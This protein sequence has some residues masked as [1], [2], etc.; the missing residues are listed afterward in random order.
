MIS[1]AMFIAALRKGNPDID[2]KRALSI[3]NEV[4]SKTDLSALSPQQ[5]AQLAYKLAE[6]SCK[7]EKKYADG[8]MI[9]TPYGTIP[10]QV[11]GA[12]TEMPKITDADPQV[13][14]NAK[15]ALLGNQ[16]NVIA[17]NKFQDPNL[18]NQNLRGAYDDYAKRMAATGVSASRAV[19][20]TPE[21]EGISTRNEAYNKAMTVGKEEAVNKALLDQYKEGVVAN[22]ALTTNLGVANENALKHTK[23]ASD[24]AV[25]MQENKYKMAYGDPNSLSS[26]AAR[27]STKAA[28]KA[29]GQY[30]D[31]QIA[32]MVPDNATAMY[33][34]PVLSTLVPNAQ[35]ILKEATEIKK[36]DAERTKFLAD[37]GH[38]SAQAAMVKEQTKGEQLRNQMRTA[39]NATMIGADGKLNMSGGAVPTI[40]GGGDVSV[41]Y[42]N[43]SAESTA[44]GTEKAQSA[45]QFKV[46]N[47][48]VKPEI[49]NAMQLLQ[50]TY[51]G[52]GGAALAKWIPGNDQLMVAN[53]IAKIYQAYPQ[54][55]PQGVGDNLKRQ[56]ASPDYNGVPNLGL[57][58]AQSALLLADAKKTVERLQEYRTK[59]T[60]FEKGGGRSSEFYASPQAKGVGGNTAPAAKNSK[61]WT[62]HTD[63]K[64]N[65]A[66]VSP[67]GKQYEE[68]K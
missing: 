2:P 24:L 51:T 66:Y 60:E 23:A 52:K 44:A 4:S 22:T 3:W 25:T 30:T 14:E 58:P 26:E 56:M 48:M 43:L 67:D 54:A 6:H 15:Q 53:T 13:L 45:E 65:K 10:G 38:S 8:G 27:V 17:G 47:T 40:S 5:G 11:T 57:T 41:S 18:L 35:K 28:L 64:G 31:A 49:D 33:L 63:A 37:A 46:Y 61:G 1:Q 7:S 16:A 62:L 34:T 21:G 9:E 50:K 55:L 68:V 32:K 59:Q 39:S 42:P 20:M 29:S 36:T 19:G 12:P